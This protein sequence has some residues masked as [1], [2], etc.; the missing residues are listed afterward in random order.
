MF[1]R[2][3]KLI[4]IDTIQNLHVV[5]YRSYGTH[6]HLYIKG[7][8]LDNPEIQFKEKSNF[9]QTL[10]NTIQ[11]FDTHEIANVEIELQIAGIVLRPTR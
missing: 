2:I 5:I 10:I 4:G 1:K 8:V 7:R 11:Q 3:K 6:F 9:F